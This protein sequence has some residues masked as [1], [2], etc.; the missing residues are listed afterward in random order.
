MLLVLSAFFLVAH[1]NVIDSF[2]E[3]SDTFGGETDVPTEN[4]IDSWEDDEFPSEETA[5]TVTN[6][7]ESE[8]DET[9]DLSHLAADFGNS[10]NEFV[11]IAE[12][13]Q[14]LNSSCVTRVACLK[15]I[16]SVPFQQCSSSAVQELKSCS[17]AVRVAYRE[18]RTK[19]TVG[20][21]L[22]FS[23]L[24]FFLTPTPIFSFFSNTLV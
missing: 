10:Y 22:F 17:K 2:E 13:R 5:E 9:V 4:L 3:V 21:R 8:E 12:G 19:H 23:F 24:L 11:D 18:C 7:E 20:G 15:N 1:G 16:S 14:V 6:I